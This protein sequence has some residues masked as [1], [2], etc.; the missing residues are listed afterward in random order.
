MIVEHL[1]GQVSGV[2]LVEV[3][4]SL[5]SRNPAQAEVGDFDITLFDQ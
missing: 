4:P 2:A 5:D 3:R 1:F